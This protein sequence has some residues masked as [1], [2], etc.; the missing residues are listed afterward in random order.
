MDAI[1]KNTETYQK[2]ELYR[3]MYRTRVVEQ[4]YGRTRRD[5][6]MELIDL[7]IQLGIMY[8]LPINCKNFP[9]LKND[10]DLKKLIKQGKLKRGRKVYIHSICNG[11]H[12]RDYLIKTEVTNETKEV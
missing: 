5:N 7:G 6:I 1:L 10:P 8:K 2:W 4:P 9:Q 11:T 3:N 12:S